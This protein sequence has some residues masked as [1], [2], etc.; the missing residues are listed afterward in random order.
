M[1]CSQH[2][3]TVWCWDVRCCLCCLL[4]YS[5][6][7]I[8][9]ELVRKVRKD[10]N[11]CDPKLLCIYKSIQLPQTAS[12]VHINE[13]ELW[14]ISGTISAYYIRIDILPKELNSKYTDSK[15]ECKCRIFE[16]QFYF[17]IFLSNWITSRWSHLCFHGCFS[18]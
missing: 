17:K 3:Y 8:Y 12:K 6:S 1:Q 18:S 11:S 7:Y 5:P 9:G 16:V 4:H 14:E 10:K 15:T 2:H 13:V